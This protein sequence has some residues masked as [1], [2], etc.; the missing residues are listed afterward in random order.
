MTIST[1][2]F[3]SSS[4]GQE[5]PQDIACYARYI[6]Y[7]LQLFQF[8]QSMGQQEVVKSGILTD[9]IYKNEIEFDMKQKKSYELCFSTDSPKELH[10]FFEFPVIIMEST[11]SPTEV[12]DGAQIIR[13]LAVEIERTGDNVKEVISSTLIFDSE[14]DK[15]ETNLYSRIIL[16]TIVLFLVCGLQCW[17]FMKMIGKKVFEYTRVSIPI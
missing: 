10:V 11:S 9:T 6:D 16:K 13:Q 8:D 15:L 12:F 4:M 7:Y 14:S 1:L 5:L 2:H 17:I 3:T